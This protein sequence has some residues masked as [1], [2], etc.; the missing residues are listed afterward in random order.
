MHKRF[1]DD[2][3]VVYYNK[4]ARMIDKHTIEVF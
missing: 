1:L 4:M 2:N 3:K